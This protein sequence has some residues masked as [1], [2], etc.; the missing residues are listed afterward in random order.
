MWGSAEVT[1]ARASKARGRLE[2]PRTRLHVAIAVYVAAKDRNVDRIRAAA[3]LRSLLG[4]RPQLGDHAAAQGHAGEAIESARAATRGFAQSEWLGSAL[5]A[6]AIVLQAQGETARSK[7]LATEALE[8]L[9]ESAGNDAPPTR[10]SRALLQ[11][12]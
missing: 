12:R 8:Q 7:T 11:R 3:P 2:L 1:V 5:L 6:Q 9:Q 10:E 4:L